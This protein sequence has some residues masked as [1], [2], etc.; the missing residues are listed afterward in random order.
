MAFSVSHTTIAATLYDADSP[1][2]ETLMTYIVNNHTY[3]NEWI[4]DVSG[5]LYG[6]PAPNHAHN[7]DGTAPVAGA[8]GGKYLAVAHETAKGALFTGWKTRF[9]PNASIFWSPQ[10]TG[11][12]YA[13]TDIYAAGG[14]ARELNGGAQSAAT[15]GVLKLG[16][17]TFDAAALPNATR[18]D[19]I[20][21]L[22]FK[23]R[24]GYIKVGS[25][26]GD[27]AASQ[28]ISGLGFQ[29]EFVFVMLNEG[30]AS[31]SAP[32]MRV[33]GTYGHSSADSH[34]TAGTLIT[35]GI[36][37]I[38]SDG[39]KV[40]A[41]AVVNGTG[42]TFSYIALKSGTF[43]GERIQVDTYQGNATARTLTNSASFTPQAVIVLGTNVTAR[44]QGFYSKPEAGK[45]SSSATTQTDCQIYANGAKLTTANNVN[46][47][48][49][50]YGIVY[51]LGGT[52]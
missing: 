52:R 46:A 35:D 2:T 40:G 19:E 32:V 22:N 7:E 50:N 14:A 10:T 48:G 36:I 28:E 17:P 20:A 37:S 4:G 8:S 31:A 47:A 26:T 12:V 30:A 1:L 3:N 24:T 21:M 13:M 39:F 49:T 44:S 16:G 23:T 43:D 9:V 25:Y 33:A 41:N 11:T 5:T 38:T 45:I 15:D 42:S 18:G 6:T 34:N 29:P 27:G 51:L